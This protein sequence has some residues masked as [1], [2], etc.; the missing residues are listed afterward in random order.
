MSDP[1]KNDL[2]TKQLVQGAVIAALYTVLTLL[3]PATTAG[4]V[5]FRISEALTMLAALTPSAIPGLAIGCVLAN[6]MHG[7][8]I[9]DIVFGS[10]ATLL[11]AVMTFLTRKNIFVA[12]I[13]PAVFNG[14]II[15]PL[16]KY[17]Y[18]LDASLIVL[19]LSVAAGEAVIC[20]LL[21]IPLVKG[22]ARTNIFKHGKQ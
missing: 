9:L 6:V 19:I 4:T 3:L 13:W 1:K 10:L 7:A 2:Y 8:I 21:G 22:L 14:L 15:G 17:A 11:A 16:L 20:Y 5:E 18:H 12:A